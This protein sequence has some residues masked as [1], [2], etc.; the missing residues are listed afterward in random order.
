MRGALTS[1]TRSTEAGPPADATMSGGGGTT[2]TTNPLQRSES[3]SPRAQ[4]DADAPLPPTSPNEAA[5]GG[6][7]NVKD[8]LLDSQ[9][10]R[11]VNRMCITLVMIYAGFRFLGELTHEDFAKNN[12]QLRNWY[13]LSLDCST[14]LKT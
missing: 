11:G 7:V 13:H 4:P 9:A 14:L 2:V 6:R 8:L 5:T 10:H 1:A 12:V 3:P